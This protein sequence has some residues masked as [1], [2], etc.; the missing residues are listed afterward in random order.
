M[1][2]F[3]LP[4][5]ADLGAAIVQ[6]L[7]VVFLA[8]A[9]QG[10]IKRCKASW[11][12]RRGPPL[13]QAYA[14]LAKLLRKQSL[15]PE[16]S[17][18]VFRATPWIV[19]GATLAAATL[20]PLVSLHGPLS[21]GDVIAITALLALARFAQA[22]AA[23]DTGSA[24]GGMGASREMAIA[25]L[26]EP[27]LLAAIFALAIPAGTTDPGRL[28]A[29]G[30]D[31]GWAALGPSRL[32][33]LG[34]LLVVAVAE[35]G[36][37]PVDNPDTH[38]ELTMVHEGMLLEYAGPQ[39]AILQLAAF[40]KQALVLGLIAAVVLP[41]GLDQPW[42]LALAALGFKWAALGALLATVESVYV[43]LRILH[44]PDLLATAFTLGGL[45]LVARGVFGA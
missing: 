41:W 19:L 10:W 20:V 7:L 32:L 26:I 31:S 33:A 27:A 15:L 11:Q 42:P 45:S 22:L 40:V 12:A 34:A 29:D 24:F 30:L 25:S 39:L 3:P 35:T 36:R 6:A 5:A 43:K 13:L 1:N 18:W 28:A 2:I 8:P 37:I 16:P 21:A 4:T 17:S 23:L 9:L 38:L 44:L 14:D